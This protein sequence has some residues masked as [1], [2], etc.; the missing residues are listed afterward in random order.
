MAGETRNA[1]VTVP[2]ALIA[3]ISVVSAVYLAINFIYVCFIP[4]KEMANNNLIAANLLQILYGKSGRKVFEALVIMSSLGCINAMIMTGSRVT[5]AM[6]RD[7][8]IFKYIGEVNGNFGTPLRAIVI[9]AAWSALLIIVGTF[10]KLLFFTGIVVWLFFALAV[11]GLFIL[12]YK[13]PTIERPFKVW[14]YP[15]IP[16][17][18]I[19]ICMALVIN[20]VIFY[21]FQSFIGLCILLSGIPVYIISQMISKN[22]L[23]IR[24]WYRIQRRKE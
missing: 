1:G 19:L 12:R 4:I 3:G 8:I 11:A 2:H 18:F 10:N 24:R 15:F 20:T 23:S 7:N 14:G 5:Y 16:A 21:P 6:A 17:F 13:Y 22:S 9:N